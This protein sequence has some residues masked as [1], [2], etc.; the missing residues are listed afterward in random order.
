MQWRRSQ[1]RLIDPGWMEIEFPSTRMKKMKGRER[2]LR[3]RSTWSRME[4][5]HGPTE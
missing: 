1:H 2:D 3:G 5:S 4:G